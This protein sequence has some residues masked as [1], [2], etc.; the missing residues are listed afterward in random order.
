[1]LHRVYI[2]EAGDR[3][4]S[5]GSSRHFIVSAIVV[6]DELDAQARNELAALRQELGRGG[7]SLFGLGRAQALHFRKLS[8]SHKIRAAQAL[9]GSSIAVVSNAIVCKL[10]IQQ[11]LPTG[12]LAFISQP[13]PMYLYSLR[14][15]LERVSWY[16]R[17]NGGGS[18][19]VTFAHVKRFRPEKLHDYR[20]ALTASGTEIHWPS[21]MGHK[22]Q[23]ADM[24]SIELLQFADM[25]ASALLKAVEPDAFGNIEARYLLEMREKLYRR[26]GGAITS[27]GLKVFPVS[28]C[29]AGGSLHWLRSL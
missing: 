28:E 3:G 24:R 18:S 10:R 12:D 1:M 19:I 8:H 21:F 25:A 22:F 15:L 20:D 9:N 5:A 14:L 16:I 29:N 27:Y 4:K 2:D 17:D 13:D 7:G 26:A 23:V 6:R 11:P